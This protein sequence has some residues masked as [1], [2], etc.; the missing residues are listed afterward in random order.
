MRGSSR[1]SSIAQGTAI[2]LRTPPDIPADR[3][4]SKGGSKLRNLTGA[5]VAPAIASALIAGCSTQH[6]LTP[7]AS[8]ASVA[9][10][11]APTEF[12]VVPG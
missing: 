10:P 5:F 4:S 6:T 8:A 7:Q 11:G 1:N 3:R 2:Y 9:A 12:R